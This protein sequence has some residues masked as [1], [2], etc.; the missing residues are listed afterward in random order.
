MATNYDAARLAGA[1]STGW[2]SALSVSTREFLNR[3]DLVGSAFPASRYLV[4]ALLDPVDW[5]TA[6]VVVE[7][8]PG[9]GPLTRAMLRRMPADSRLVT[10]DVS[11]HFTR[12]LRRTIDDPRLLAITT[13]A[14]SVRATLAKHELGSADLIVTGIPF[15]TMSPDEG[16][17]VLD[18]SAQVLHPNGELLAYQMRTAIAPLLAPRFDEVERSYVWRNIPPCHLYWARRPFKPAL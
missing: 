8:G 17:K 13:S 4:D 11:P 14:A 10:L 2:R 15:S 7:F 12:H 9:T 6:R 18:A 5:S 16:A 3:P 1:R